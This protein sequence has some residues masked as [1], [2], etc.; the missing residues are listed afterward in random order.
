MEKE[1]AKIEAQR[2]EA[3][4]LA[5]EEATAIKARA[6]AAAIKRAEEAEAVRIEAGKI[7]DEIIAE[8]QESA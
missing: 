5:D 1:V 7:N 2:A 8:A 6:Q 4:R 3:K